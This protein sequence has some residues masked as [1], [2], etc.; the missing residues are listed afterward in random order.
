M[1]TDMNPLKAFLFIMSAALNFEI[2]EG[3]ASKL[4][5]RC[6]KPMEVGIIMMGVPTEL[7]TSYHLKLYRHDLTEVA[8]R[9]NEILIVVS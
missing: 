2:A 8:N 5:E 1:R 7:D 4:I 3:F 9:G 6:D